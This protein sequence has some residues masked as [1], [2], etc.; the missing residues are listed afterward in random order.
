MT[1]ARKRG[2]PVRRKPTQAELVLGTDEA[3]LLDV[4]DNVLSKGV[5][6][7]GELTIA[8]AHVDLVYARLSLLLCAADRVMPGEPTNPIARR[9]A[10]HAARERVKRAQR[11]G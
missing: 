8:L 3:T 2:L 10:R 7:T 11:R 5:V 6:L 9:S 4:V 1:A